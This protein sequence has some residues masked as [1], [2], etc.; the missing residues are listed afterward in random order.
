MAKN[1]TIFD[2]FFYV[3]HMVCKKIKYDRLGALFAL[4]QT[5]YEG[6][7]KAKR[8]EQRIY[9]CKKCNAWHLTSKKLK[10]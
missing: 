2:I 3:K 9:F 1:D 5:K 6:N 8:N 4:S 7:F 10:T